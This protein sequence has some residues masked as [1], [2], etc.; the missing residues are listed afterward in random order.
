M[1]YDI[2]ISCFH[3]ETP[4]ELYFLY[5]LYI[6]ISCDTNISHPLFDYKITF[7]NSQHEN[8][9]SKGDFVLK[10]RFQAF[11]LKNSGIQK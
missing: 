2:S 4:W 8:T 1:E 11:I 6:T 5:I 7:E 9:N 3:N 10:N